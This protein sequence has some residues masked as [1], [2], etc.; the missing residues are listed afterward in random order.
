MRSQHSSVPVIPSATAKGR[1]VPRPN[2][3]SLPDITPP[4]SGH[5]ALAPADVRTRRESI[6]V[7]C[8]AP[9]LAQKIAAALDTRRQRP[10]DLIHSSPGDGLDQLLRPGLTAL[11]IEL[12]TSD[13]ALT[14]LARLRAV[15]PDAPIIVLM[16]G[17]D[18]ATALSAIEAGASEVVALTAAGDFNGAELAQ[19]A[20]RALA[21]HG[22]TVNGSRSAAPSQ[23]VQ[24]SAPLVLVQ[25]APDAMVVLDRHGCVAF[26]NP[27]AEELLGRPA[28]ALMGKPFDLDIGKGDEVTIVQPGGETRIAEVDVVKTERG[29]VPARVATFTDITVR[30]K[31]ETALKTAQGGRDAALRRSSR[32]F[33]RVSHDLRTPLT[34]I[35]GFADL[36]Q[37][38]KLNDPVRAREYAASISDAGRAMLDMVEDLLSV[39]DANGASAHDPCDLVKLVRNTAHFIQRTQ[40]GSGDGSGALDGRGTGPEVVVDAPA[41]PMVARLDAAKL[42]RA[43]YRLVAGIARDA[44]AGTLMRLSLRQAGKQARLTVRLDGVAGRPVALPASLEDS[45]PLVTPA[46]ARTGFAAE[47][48]REAL[49]AHGGALQLAR[50]GANVVAAVITLPLKD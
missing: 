8:D 47:L 15:G 6:G 17:M 44:G 38:E 35:V 48:L 22:H 2:D 46:D 28:D 5:L 34:H 36:L 41:L 39:V 19:A 16:H 1:L 14:R 26:I 29:G 7:V 20:A 25:E 33:S 40:G 11:V 3:T 23:S 49:D 21:R 9:A 10:V 43:L 50:D 18:D 37:H 4:A 30:R 32:F 24:A 13:A 12:D 45:D 42:Q 31:L 27:A